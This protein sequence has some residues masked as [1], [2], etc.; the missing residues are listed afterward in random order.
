MNNICYR[1]NINDELTKLT[2]FTLF[3]SIRTFFYLTLKSFND[4]SILK[5]NRR[6]F[7]GKW[8]FFNRVQSKTIIKVKIEVF[9]IT[10]E[11]IKVG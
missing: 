10:F 11:L 5:C 2:R 4:L 8:D 3:S 9:K 7:W 6:V 1:V